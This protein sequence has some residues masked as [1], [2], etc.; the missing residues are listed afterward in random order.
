MS[1][2]PDAP[3]PMPPT[4]TMRLCGIYKLDGEKLVLCL[5]EAEV[6]PLLRPAEFKG[7]GEDGVYVLTYKRA[8][9]NW[10]PDV[11]MTA[12]STA[13]ESP[14]VV[15]ATRE[16]DRKSVPETSAP[17][18]P[19]VAPP[20]VLP[21]PPAPALDK[22]KDIPTIPSRSDGSVPTPD[23][24][25]PS[26]PPPVAGP[27]TPTVPPAAPATPPSD[28][29][30]LQGPWALK[31][32]D[33]NPPKPGSPG[34][35]AAEPDATFVKDRI[36]TGDGAHGRFQIDESKSPKR[37]TIQMPKDEYA[38]TAIYRLE[39]DSLVIAYHTRSSR[40]IPIDFEVDEQNE[41]TVE[42]YERVKGDPPPKKKPAIDA[43]RTDRK[44]EPPAPR[45]DRDIQKEIDQLRGH[46]KRLEQELKD[47]KQPD[48]DPFELPPNPVGKK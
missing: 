47:R 39:G 36:L 12:P 40:L 13:P 5:P 26:P 38:K 37:I 18:A 16:D 45:A 4:K 34:S 6:S 27:G 23:L 48:P 3:A 15:P 1:S 21:I 10:K 24:A 33:G 8:A 30:R 22:D 44:A 29:E 2:R 25:P 35:N 17:V 42:V 32:R 20:I 11:R 41:V 14:P 28:L 7:D 19:A 46:L 43:P 31:Q 9:K